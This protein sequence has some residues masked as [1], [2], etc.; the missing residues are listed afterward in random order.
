VYDKLDITK[1]REVFP[2]FIGHLLG[3]EGPA[4]DAP[5][6]PGT[7]RLPGRQPVDI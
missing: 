2:L 5:V 4:S 7:N 1:E 6:T 3:S